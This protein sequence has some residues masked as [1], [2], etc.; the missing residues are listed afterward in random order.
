[1]FHTTRFLIAVLI[2]SITG[3]GSSIDPRCATCAADELCVVAFDGTCR[4]FSVRCAKKTAQCQA[5]S[6]ND[7]CDVLCGSSDGGPSRLTCRGPAC[8]TSGEYPNAVLCYGP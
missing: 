4:A 5:A 7:S 6:C 1:M 3:C 2:L 8:P